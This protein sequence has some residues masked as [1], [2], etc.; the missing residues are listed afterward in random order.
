MFTGEN[1]GSVEKGEMM[2][3]S[4]CSTPNKLAVF[5]HLPVLFSRAKAMHILLHTSFVGYVSE[6]MTGE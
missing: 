3:K 1:Q 6:G 2:W 5:K 4:P